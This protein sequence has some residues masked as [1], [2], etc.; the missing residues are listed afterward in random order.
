MTAVKSVTSM[1]MVSGLKRAPTG[2]CIQPLAIRIHSADRLEPSATSQV[3]AR[4]DTLD[5]LSQPKKKRP[6]KVAS[7]KK[8]ISPSMA[9][10]A[11]KTSPT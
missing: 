7:R 10:G 9:S 11:P 2:C 1:R 5:S 4:W 3:T 6:M 8:A